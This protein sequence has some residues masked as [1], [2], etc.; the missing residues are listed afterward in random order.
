[1]LVVADGAEPDSA[2][3]E[4][5]RVLALPPVR[6][7]QARNAGV[8]AASTPYVAFLDDDDA[9]LQGR[10]ARQVA[11]LETNPRA[12]L[13]F[14]R[15]RVIDGDGRPLDEWNRLLAARFDRLAERGATPAE[16]LATRCP[17]YTS[18]TM[19]R[20]EP[21]LAVGGYDRRFDAYED[22][23]LY[24]RLARASVLVPCAGE[25]VAAYRLHGANTPSELLYE[26]ALR[27]VE[28]HLPYARGRERRLLLERR[29]D[30]LWGL[31][32]YPAV[33]RSALRS[34][35]GDPLLLA[36]GRFAKRLAGS[37][38]PARVL[39]ARR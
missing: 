39:A 3:V 28:K 12:G 15:V 35:L 9:V 5:A 37:A 21:F 6:R 27:I 16:I 30:A 22:L 31:G 17:I 20:R 7:S 38:L 18:A 19:V 29:V 10:L 24:L 34:A 25:P 4:G 33:R 8:E 11:A 32:E 13:S 36:H 14:G 2:A 1:M 26:G 23:D